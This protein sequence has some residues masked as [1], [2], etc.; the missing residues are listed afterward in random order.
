[1]GKANLYHCDDVA[2]P[3]AIMKV[4]QA[5]VVRQESG[6][7]AH[8]GRQIL[9]VLPPDH[10]RWIDFHAGNHN[11]VGMFEGLLNHL[12]IQIS[13]EHPTDRATAALCKLKLEN[14]KRA[15]AWCMQ[16]Y[17]KAPLNVEPFS[18]DDY[19]AFRKFGDLL[20]AKFEFVSK[21]FQAF[22]T[23]GHPA[24]FF[25]K[26]FADTFMLAIV[27]EIN[28]G[29]ANFYGSKEEMALAIR[30]DVALLKE[31]QSPYDSFA[32]VNQLIL[33]VAFQ[34][35]PA[36]SKDNNEIKSERFKVRKAYTAMIKA[37]EAYNTQIRTDPKPYGLRV[38][39]PQDG[40][41]YAPMKRSKGKPAD[42]KMT[43][44]PGDLKHLNP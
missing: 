7:E 6:I 9:V 37:I 32:P 19:K 39:Y 25:S 40:Q 3:V 13:K 26:G 33:Q 41:I 34:L 24:P 35:M 15:I 27:E 4:N 16:L 14:W 17:L 2:L 18:S 28:L 21:L 43:Q 10:Q 31:R 23:I 29:F 38:A 44:I 20:F 36:N 5:R 12:G 1:M 8:P 42:R 22:E 11:I 30:K